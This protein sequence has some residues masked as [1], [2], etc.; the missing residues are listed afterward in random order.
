MAGP[1]RHLSMVHVLAIMTDDVSSVPGHYGRRRELS[2]INCPLTSTYMNVH[3]CIHTRARARAHTHTH[4]QFLKGKQIAIIVHS[5][6]SQEA[7]NAKM[8]RINPGQ[9]N[10]WSHECAFC[11]WIFLVRSDKDPRQ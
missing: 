3:I 10:T 7:T 11:V 5:A 8:P 4:T 9:G 6:S 1:I 2:I